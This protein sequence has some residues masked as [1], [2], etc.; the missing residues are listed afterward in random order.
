MHVKTFSFFKG[1][2]IKD[3]AKF[4][5]NELNTFEVMYQE[6][7]T[8]DVGMLSDILSYSLSQKSKKIRPLITLLVAK[9]CGGVSDSTF[10]SAII[11]ELLHT[12]SLAHD[13]VLDNSDLRR[14]QPTINSRWGN[15]AAILYG[16]Y[17]FGK[18]LQLIHTKEDFEL[19]PIYSKIARELPMG[20][21]LQ[22]DILEKGDISRQSYF[23]VIDFK[24]SSLLGASAYIGAKTAQ[25]DKDYT[26]YAEEFGR[27]L[28]R[29]F[30]I[31]DDILDF[32]IS[33]TSG[34]KFGN[35]IKECKFTLPI[36]DYIEQLEE[37]VKLNAINFVKQ[38]DKS[39]E[40]VLKFVMD[41]AESGSLKKTEEQVKYYSNKAKEILKHLPENQYREVLEQLVETLIERNN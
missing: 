41:I 19:L 27:L 5:E 7:K 25:T 23:N 15:N 21:L 38:K 10:R 37:S 26:L 11:V 32:A 31:K 40:E 8:S 1:M 13:D 6:C 29:A 2:E 9:A 34:K 30:Q 12:A 39:D 20:E 16:D 4:I 36:L 24:T 3:I 28:G 33:Q 18:S 22:K 35:D 14:N 17:L